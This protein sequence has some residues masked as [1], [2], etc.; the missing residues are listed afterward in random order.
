MTKDTHGDPFLTQQACGL[1]SFRMLLIRWR[2]MPSTD[3]VLF[4]A[5]EKAG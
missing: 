1:I 2:P 5:V 4:A 3:L